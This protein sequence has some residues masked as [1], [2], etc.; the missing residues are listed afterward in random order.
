MLSD[1]WW[2]Q[3]THPWGSESAPDIT[4]MSWRRARLAHDII[5]R[6]YTELG[7]VPMPHGPTHGNGGQERFTLMSQ[8]CLRDRRAFAT[9][10]PSDE[11]WREVPQRIGDLETWDVE[12]GPLNGPA[13]WRHT[14]GLAFNAL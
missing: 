2:D 12:P 1:E 6:W 5:W 9:L 10:D 4:T 11:G 14:R 7:I 3:R 13:I 8:L